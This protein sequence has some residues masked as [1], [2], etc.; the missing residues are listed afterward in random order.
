MSN[1]SPG[2]SNQAA[3][4]ALRFQKLKAEIHRQL[5][6][7]L[8]ISKLGHWKPERLRREVRALAT[9]LTNNSSELLGEVDRERLIDEI[10]SE[11]FG[12]GPLDG[13]MRDPSVSD[14][15][16][17]GPSMIY[18]ERRG[19][20]EQT[21][22]LFADNAH[23]LQIIQRIAA[24]VGRRADES[25]PM[26][27][28]RLPDGSRVNAIIP[29]LSL[30]GPVLSIRRFGVRLTCEDLLANATMPPQM[31]TLLRGCVEA[32]LSIL[33]SGGTG[34]G[35]TT[36]LNTLSKYIPLDERLVTIEDSAELKLQQP[37]VVRLETRPANLEG[38]GEVKQRDLVRNALRM[39]PDR[40]IVGEVR[41]AE[42]LD[43]L[44]AM[45]TGHEGSLTTIHANDTRDAL[46]RLEMMVMMSGFELPVP[47]IRQY[48]G[49]A[50]TLVIQL[51]RLKGGPRRVMRIS[52]IIG[53][54]GRRY[55]VKDIFGFRQTGV[56]HGI[57]VGEFYATGHVPRFLTRL[58]ASGIDLP[59]ELFAERV[60]CRPEV[61]T[62]AAPS[63]LNEQ[64]MPA[65]AANVPW[66][67][68]ENAH[69]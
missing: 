2:P 1:P 12:L 32:R 38:T 63:R 40:I 35:K 59:P 57:A 17:N 25:S 20:L 8:D 67:T 39:R 53:V 56:R 36:M 21:D 51:A 55:Q 30:D 44:Q 3:P 46:T 41:G 50:I 22:L 62:I 58:T 43:M 28:A 64:I 37:H 10:M 69:E 48:I 7:M 34:S 14:I 16:V 19:R 27:D 65:E 47:V 5:I 4:F 13:L 31:L 11:V 15:L 49:S 61:E 54:K 45:N 66:T 33:I 26:V 60:L 29:P 6:E 52:E 9:R 68:Q 23:L 18:V 42:A 24:R